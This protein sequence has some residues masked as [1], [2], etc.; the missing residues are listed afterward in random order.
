MK[1]YR[2]Y[3]GRCTEYSADK[4]AALISDA[5]EKGVF[6]DWLHMISDRKP[7]PLKKLPIRTSSLYNAG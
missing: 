5:Y 3:L 2:V 6:L 7:K 1:K 4:I